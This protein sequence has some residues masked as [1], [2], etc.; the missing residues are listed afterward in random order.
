MLTDILSLHSESHVLAPADNF[1]HLQVTL[2]EKI[3]PAV[4]ASLVHNGIGNLCE[5]LLPAAVVIK[6]SRAGH[7]AL[8]RSPG[9]YARSRLF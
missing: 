2:R 8:G 3:Q 9:L 5:V 6:E 1:Q 7:G 4:R